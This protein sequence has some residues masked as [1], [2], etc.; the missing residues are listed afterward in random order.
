MKAIISNTIALKQQLPHILLAA[1]SAIGRQCE[2]YWLDTESPVNYMALICP[3]YRVGRQG[4]SINRKFASRYIDAQTLAA[5]LLPSQYSS[6]PLEAPQLY[7]AANQAIIPGDD[8]D[9]YRPDSHTMEAAGQSLT[10]I[11]ADFVDE[12]ITALTP[13]MT[14]KTGDRLI[15]CGHA[16]AVPISTRTRIE[17]TLDGITVLKFKAI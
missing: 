4:K 8:S 10:F 7:L 13:Y 3:C 14:I 17:A 2:P 15:D 11:S 6:H 9:C 12:A 1:D 5:V 16:I